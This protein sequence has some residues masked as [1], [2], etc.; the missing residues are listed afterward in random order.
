MVNYVVV[1]EPSHTTRWFSSTKKKETTITSRYGQVIK[2]IVITTHT[3][4]MRP[5]HKSIIKI[6]STRKKFP[7]HMTKLQYTMEIY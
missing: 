6:G 2:T 4:T 1:M 3:V 7:I 5:S